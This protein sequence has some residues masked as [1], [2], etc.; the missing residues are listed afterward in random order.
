MFG[1]PIHNLWNGKEQSGANH[2]L[3]TMKWRIFASLRR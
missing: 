3:F 1:K 2:S